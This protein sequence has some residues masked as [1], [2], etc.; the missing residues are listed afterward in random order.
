[1]NPQSRSHSNIYV[2]LLF[3]AIAEIDNK[4]V[5]N[6]TIFCSRAQSRAERSSLLRRQHE[7][8]TRERDSKTHN[9]NLYIKNLDDD[10]DDAK[11]KEAFSKF[12][13]ITS[14]KVCPV[15]YTLC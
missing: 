14:A 9:L 5:N 2:I 1:M 13:S 7:E 15:Q 3:Q 11:L 10:V 6:M 12:G 4:S 8:R